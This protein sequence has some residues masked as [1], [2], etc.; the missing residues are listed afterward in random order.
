MEVQ[1]IVIWLYL[2]VVYPV[3]YNFFVM[4]SLWPLYADNNYL[5]MWIIM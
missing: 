3:S 4:C 5:Y 1:L 2:I